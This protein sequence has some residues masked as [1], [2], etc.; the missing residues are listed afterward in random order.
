LPL[1]IK[2]LLEPDAR[3]KADRRANYLYRHSSDKVDTNLLILLHGAGDSHIKYHALAKKMTLPQTASMSLSA[4]AMDNSFVTLPFGLGC[5]WFAEMDYETGIT[6]QPNDPR[7]ISSLRHAT[8]KLNTLIER[9]IE[10]GD[11]VPERIFL[12]GFSSGACLAM[13]TCFNRTIERK[14]PLGGAVC[15][16]GGIRCFNTF[17]EEPKD[18]TRK[19]K[20]LTPLLIIGGSDDEVFPPSAV[21]TAEEIYNSQVSCEAEKGKYIHTY[22]EDG[23]GHAMIGGPNEMKTLMKFFAEK[24]VRRMMAMEGWSEVATGHSMGK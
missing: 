13:E 15:V 20:E 19:Q 18:S 17:S 14:R 22:I 8:S 2:H 21:K 9:L 6:L 7:R 1:P 5:T 16:A 23:K 3:I 11:W 24:M 10:E 4:N 12:F